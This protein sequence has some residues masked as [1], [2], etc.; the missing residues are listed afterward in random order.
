MKW[1]K[2]KVENNST[3]TPHPLGYG[4]QWRVRP[5]LPFT[6]PT[7]PYHYR[8]SFLRGRG[9]T[10]AI[11]IVARKYRSVYFLQKKCAPRAADKCLHFLFFFNPF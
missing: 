8:R 1:F 4:V 3:T 9:V 7:L 11:I 2:N 5:P 10:C 6:L